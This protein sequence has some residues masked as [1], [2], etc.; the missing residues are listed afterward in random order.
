[1]N[2]S[3]LPNCR[4]LG[5]ESEAL[6]RD[7]FEKSV[8]IDAHLDELGM[9]LAEETVFLLFDNAPGSVLN[10]EGHCLIARSIIGP[11]RNMEGPLN[12][13]DWVQAPVYR[14]VIKASTWGEILEKC[15]SEWESLQRQA[16]KVAPSFMILA[17]RRLN[18]KL[19]LCLEV[20]FKE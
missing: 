11:K 18:P 5:L 1:M 19:E 9:E 14:Q 2:K 3:L 13:T 12:L 17:K 6:G 8:F 4:F 16:K 20:L 15:Y 10:G 7:W